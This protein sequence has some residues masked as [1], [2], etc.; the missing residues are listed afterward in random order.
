[1]CAYTN[2]ELGKLVKITAE[3]VYAQRAGGEKKERED[4]PIF[5][6]R[7]QQRSLG[8]PRCDEIIFTPDGIKIAWDNRAFVMFTD[9]D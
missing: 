8:V 5:T 7:D 4:K 9:A 2:S 1:M 3:G 6:F